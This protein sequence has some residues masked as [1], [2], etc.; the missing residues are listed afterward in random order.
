MCELC[1]AQTGQRGERACGTGKEHADPITILLAA[2]V[3]GIFCPP[4]T[5]AASGPYTIS[6]GHQRNGQQ[7]ALT[8]LNGVGGDLQRKCS[9]IGL[10]NVDTEDEADPRVLPPN[11]SLSFPQLDV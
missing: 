4:L 5:T 11:V 10:G 6:H 7:L 3:V 9:P 2:A 8:A 1:S